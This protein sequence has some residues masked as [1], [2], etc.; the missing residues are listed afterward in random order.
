MREQ[1][2]SDKIHRLFQENCG[3]TFVSMGS[4]HIGSIASML[5]EKGWKVQEIRD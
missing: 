3:I 5:R 4:F 1:K 2:M